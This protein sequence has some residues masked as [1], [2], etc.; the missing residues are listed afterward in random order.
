MQKGSESLRLVQL[1][2][3][4]MFS[5]PKRNL[6][7]QTDIANEQQLLGVIL[8]YKSLRRASVIRLTVDLK[9][10]REI[11]GERSRGN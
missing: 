7:L 8:P 3:R 4:V 1:L 11:W 2:G 10:Y 9:E 6:L 5:Q